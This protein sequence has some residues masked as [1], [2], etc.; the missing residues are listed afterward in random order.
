MKI[1]GAYDV[2]FV[3]SVSGEGFDFQTRF[4]QVSEIME[5]LIRAISAKPVGIEG[6]DGLVFGQEIYPV[7]CGSLDEGERAVA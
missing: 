3:A 1:R 7:V 5:K 6:F 4:G 2:V